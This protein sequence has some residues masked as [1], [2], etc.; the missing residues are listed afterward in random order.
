MPSIEFVCTK[1]DETFEH[2][3]SFADVKDEMFMS[4]PVCHGSVPRVLF[5]QTLEPHFYGTGWH[6]PSP[7][8][9]F[10]YKTVS[11]ETGN[12]YSAG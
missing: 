7:T 12:K 8:K 2:L 10:N 4:C 3:F 11:Q 6:K 5:S 1:C 9:R